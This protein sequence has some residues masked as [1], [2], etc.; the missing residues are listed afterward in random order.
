MQND[1]EQL[2][3]RIRAK[4]VLYWSLR[5][6]AVGSLATGTTLWPEGW[7]INPLATPIGLLLF[8]GV[9][10]HYLQKFLFGI[11]F[12]APKTLYYDFV[13][14]FWALILMIV[15]QSVMHQFGWAPLQN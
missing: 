11:P 1:A 6:V 12:F 15:A 2:A 5:F 10:M 13:A 8:I 9:S 7:S 14:V 3:E 4:P